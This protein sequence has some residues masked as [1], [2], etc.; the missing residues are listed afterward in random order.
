MPTQ[1]DKN[2]DSQLERF[3]EYAKNKLILVNDYIYS[4]FTRT[5]TH[6]I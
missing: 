2:D 5:T 6:T 1:H 4:P 3:Y